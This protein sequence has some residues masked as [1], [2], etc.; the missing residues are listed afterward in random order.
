MR[1]YKRLYD[2]HTAIT[3]DGNMINNLKA[4][5]ITIT[6]LNAGNKAATGSQIETGIRGKQHPGTEQ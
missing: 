5:K 1:E 2:E 6:D 3:G 4:S